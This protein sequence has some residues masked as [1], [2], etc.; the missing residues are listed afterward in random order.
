MKLKDNNGSDALT[1]ALGF[2]WCM[3]NFRHGNRQIDWTIP[4]QVSEGGIPDIFHILI[5]YWFKPV[6]YLDP[7]SKLPETTEKPGYFLGFAVNEYLY[8]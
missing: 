6:L 8:Q 3:I 4:E 2:A 7:V 1:I 5:C